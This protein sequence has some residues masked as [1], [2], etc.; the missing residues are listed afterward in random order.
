ME[1]ETLRAP[2][3]A[4]TGVIGAVLVVVFFLI[5]LCFISVGYT[6]WGFRPLFTETERQANTKQQK[7]VWALIVTALVIILVLLLT[8]IALFTV[9]Y[10]EQSRLFQPTLVR[11]YKNLKGDWYNLKHGGGLLHYTPER[12]TGSRRVFFLHGNS[13][14]LS[15]YAPALDTLKDR[16]YDVW[17]IEYAGFGITKPERLGFTTAPNCDSV[18][19]DVEEAWAIC[20][21]E[22]TIAIGF[23]IGGAI[24]GEVYETFTP[25]PAQIVFLNT[26]ASFPQLVADKVGKMGCVV[27]PFLRTQWT[28]PKPNRFKGKVTIVY[29][30]DDQ[31]VPPS[32]GRHL[33]EIFKSLHPKCIALQSG[34]HRFSALNHQEEWVNDQALLSAVL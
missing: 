31:V 27:T 16:G 23:S 7:T 12:K 2:P 19:T 10:F 29:T 9:R 25:Q 21:D 1:F 22:N 26:F 4:V 15:K 5:V 6:D 20:G 13:Y 32:H 8:V 18:L 14:D 3:Y 30:L 33:C 34:G 17:A 24:L 11:K 28:T